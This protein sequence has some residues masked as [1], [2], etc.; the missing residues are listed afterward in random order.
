[1][2]RT[3]RSGNAAKAAALENSMY[4]TIADNSRLVRCISDSL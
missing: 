2:I 3:L 4:A 1:M